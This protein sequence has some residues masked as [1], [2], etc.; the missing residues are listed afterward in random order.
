MKPSAPRQLCDNC[1]TS[2][3]AT[4][5]IPLQVRAPDGVFNYQLWKREP[6]LDTYRCAVVFSW[7]EVLEAKERC[8]LCSSN[9]RKAAESQLYAHFD[10]STCV[11]AI[12]YK[13]ED[14]NGIHSM[15]V[16]IQ[17]DKCS[18]DELSHI[19]DLLWLTVCPLESTSSEG[20]AAF[21]NA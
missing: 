9:F 1:R 4:E 19:F 6:A 21:A 7:E 16:L 20:N 5:Q 18:V 11:V 17:C 14:T 15:R 8:I 13:R 12:K 2:I 3:K 10:S